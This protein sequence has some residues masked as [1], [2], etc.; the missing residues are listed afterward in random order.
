MEGLKLS[1]FQVIF[2]LST[3]VFLRGFIE[4]FI[5][6]SNHAV[7]A[8]F[9]DVF[10]HYPLWYFVIFIGVI[11]LLKL[12]SKQHIDKVTSFVVCG[13][14]ILITPPTV[15]MLVY[16]HTIPYNFIVGSYAELWQYFY[17]WM[18]GTRAIGFGI[19]LEIALVCL[20]SAFYIYTK[21]KS[22][23]K[24][25]C[26]FLGVY[27]IIFFML[28]IP[29]YIFSLIHLGDIVPVSTSRI[30]EYFL[31]ELPN[32]TNMSQVSILNSVSLSEVQPYYYMSETVASLFLSKIFY[33][34]NILLLLGVGLITLRKQFFLYFKNMRLTRII[35]YQL[36][37]F[38]GL[39]VGLTQSGIE[40]IG[41]YSLVSLCV[42]VLAFIFAW[43]HAVWENDEVDRGIDMISNSERPLVSTTISL[44][45]WKQTKWLFLILALIAGLLSSYGVCMILIMFMMLYHLY[46]CPPFRLK[47]VVG[48]SSVIIGVNA[49]LVF[50]AGYLFGT[51]SD[52]LATLPY[53][54][55]FGF[56]I[57]IF[58][59]ENIKNLKDI[60][61][62]KKAGIQTL[63]VLLGKY[64][65]IGTGA[66]VSLSFLLAPL[67]FGLTFSSGILSVISSGVVFWLI[68]KK[69]FIESHVMIW[70][71]MYAIGLFV[72]TVLY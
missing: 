5:N 38:F 8:S 25:L 2:L 70:Y 17:T 26:A 37:L 60:E 28:T 65:F 29:V 30:Q 18:S 15:D 53:T 21:T 48:I 16:G 44:T 34:L 43:L 57:L 68:N 6:H 41:V 42:L 4:N 1:L 35:H 45:T 58:L 36:L 59:G 51:N 52:S 14:W 9:V 33:I 61:G 46:S 23:L 54:Y 3:V 24:V 64:A 20:F 71:F 22:A 12:L 32:T 67:F 47:R 50:F 31:T 27:T 13:S 10:L 49:L 72:L 55:M 19:K 40:M 63:P 62:D 56:F 39:Y 69:P 11:L 7:F 66:L